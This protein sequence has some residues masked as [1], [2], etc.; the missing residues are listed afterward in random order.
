MQLQ[1]NMMQDNDWLRDVAYEN[2]VICHWNSRYEVKNVPVWVFILCLHH[3]KQFMNIS[4]ARAHTS[5]I[6]TN[7]WFNESVEWMTEWLAH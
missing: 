3:M 2:A 6:S 7:R 5:C 1:M 4:W